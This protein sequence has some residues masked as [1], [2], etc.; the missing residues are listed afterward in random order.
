MFVAAIA[1]IAAALAPSSVRANAGHDGLRHDVRV[2][3]SHA[4]A[5]R[6]AAGVADHAPASVADAAGTSGTEC[7]A[8]C[9]GAAAMACCI[10]GV[11]PARIEIAPLATPGR[12]VPAPL[13]LIPTGVE[14]EAPAEPPRAAG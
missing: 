5:H 6:A 12:R 7:G 14:A 13:A 9:C 4:A 3:A 8:L 10:C 2:I 11:L 1:L